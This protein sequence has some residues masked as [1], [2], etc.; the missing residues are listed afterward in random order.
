V[1]DV[2]VESDIVE[3]DVEIVVI[4]L[5]KVG[6]DLRHVRGDTL[7]QCKCPELGRRK[8]DSAWR[9]HSRY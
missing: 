4:P 2:G 7:V 6:R 3:V 1:R 9:S 8:V 5:Q